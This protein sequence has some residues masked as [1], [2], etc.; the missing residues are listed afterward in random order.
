MN[1]LWFLISAPLRWE[2][3]PDVYV[4]SNPFASS[5]R[6]IGYSLTKNP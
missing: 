3:T 2:S 5:Q 6:I 4:V 1:I